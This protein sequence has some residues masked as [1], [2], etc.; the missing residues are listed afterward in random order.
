MSIQIQQRQSAAEGI[1]SKSIH[2]V[3]SA[4]YAA[5]GVQAESELDYSLDHL[6][7]LQLLGGISQS[8]EILY[9]A[10]QTQQKIVIVADF[11]AD[12]A[13]SCALAMRALRMLGFQHVDFIVPNRFEYGYG[14]TPEIVSLALGKQPNLLITVDNGIASHEG[15]AAAKAAGLQVIV[16]DHH[17]PAATLPDADAIINPNLHDD[18]FPSKMLAGVGVIFYVM[19][20]L[21]TY[22]RDIDWFT[23]QGIQQPNLASLLD[24]VALGTVADVVPLDFNNRILVA[25][26]LSR[27][28]ANHCIPGIRALLTFCRTAQDQVVASDLGFIVGP[29]LNAAGRLQDMSIGI[30]CLL[31]DDEAVAMRLARQLDDLN[32]QRKDIEAEMQQQALDV[33]HKLEQ[34]GLD[35]TTQFAITLFDPGWHQGVIG[36]L[37]SRLKERYHRPVVIFARDKGETLKGSARSVSGVHIRDV[38]DTIASQHPEI[39]HKFGGHAMAAGLSMSLAHLDTFRQALN[40]EIA[41]HLNQEDLNG[42]ILTDGELTVQDISLELAEIIRQSGPWGQGFPEPVFHGVFDVINRRIVGEK[43]LKLTLAQDG[44]LVDAI[45]FNTIDTDWPES[46]SQVRVVYRLDVNEFR[47]QRN[48]Q[49]MIENIEPHMA[50]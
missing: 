31:A 20:A 48:L 8:N 14:L 30:Q 6:L 26:G 34:D 12:G 41:R 45:A 25:Q 2:P 1:Q 11:D 33:L 32:S 43:H 16:T 19:L 27:I 18:P 15:V 29:R 17:L 5:R 7:G 50:S 23:K 46:L 9:A 36:I 10:L 4:V 3:L 40:D 42:R 37:A 39:I 38:F 44:K 24:L 47:A 35:L 49:L 22:L 13:T 21:R 28:R